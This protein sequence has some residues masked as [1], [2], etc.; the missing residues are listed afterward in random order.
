MTIQTIIKRSHQFALTAAALLACTFHASAA[1]PS[2]EAVAGLLKNLSGQTPE[3][4]WRRG[5][6]RLW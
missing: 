1:E 4:L 6:L 5:A 3:Q 2:A